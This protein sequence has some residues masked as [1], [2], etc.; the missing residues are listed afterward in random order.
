MRLDEKFSLK[1][2]AAQR[3]AATGLFSVLEVYWMGVRI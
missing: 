3:R 2:R 1:R